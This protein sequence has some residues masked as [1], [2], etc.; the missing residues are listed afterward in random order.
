MTGGA[1]TFTLSINPDQAARALTN[2]LAAASPLVLTGLAVGVGFKAGLFNIGGTGQ[3]LVG[4][5]VA[6]L[7]GGL[8]AQQP[9]PIAVTV[10]I[11]A[12]AL[13]GAALWLHPR[14]SS[15]RSRAPTRSSR[16]SCSTRSPRS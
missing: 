3:V 4:G 7:V 13:G 10:A 2:T 15:R 9:A 12:G 14:A 8:V 16:R 5:F 11:L 1:I 6:G